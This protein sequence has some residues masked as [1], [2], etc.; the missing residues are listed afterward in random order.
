VS[1][2]RI[3][4]PGQRSGSMSRVSSV[5]GVCY[6]NQWVCNVCNEYVWDIVKKRVKY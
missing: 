1:C 2:S 4:K 5:E 6:E 3:G